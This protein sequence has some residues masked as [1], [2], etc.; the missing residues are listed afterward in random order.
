MKPIIENIIF[1]LLCITDE[2]EELW[3]SDPV[4]YIRVKFD[5]FEDYISPKVAAQTLLHTVCKKRK[6]MLPNSMSFAFGILQNASSTPR[7]IDG[8][9]HLIGAV[10]DLL[11]KKDEYKS[12]I[13]NMLVAYIFPHFLSAQGYLRARACWVLHYFA[14]TRF[15]NENHLNQA[16]EHVLR[17]LLKDQELP[18][19]VEAALCL[20]V[21]ITEQERCQ[22]LMEQHCRDVTIEILK[23][24]R[25]TENEDLTNVMQKLVYVYSEQLMPI[26]VEITQHLADTFNHVANIDNEADEEN[27]DRGLAAMGIL[28]TLDSVL[29]MMEDNKEIMA[30]L[31]PIV[32]HLV[33]N[34]LNRDMLELY[35]EAMT[36]LTTLSLNVVSE[37]MWKMLPLLYNIFKKEGVDYFTDMMPILHNYATVDPNGLIS[38]ADRFAAIFEMCHGILTNDEAGEDA[39]AHA[40]KLLE[41][42]ILQF[43]GQDGFLQQAI[44]RFVEL[45]M[46]RM[47][48][49]V[50][51]DDLK[52][53]CMIVMIAA[54]YSSPEIFFETLNKLQPPNAPRSLIDTFV[55][56]WIDDTDMFL[57]LHDRKINVLGLTTLMKLPPQSRPPILNEMANQ[58]VPSCLL[59]FEKLK[60]A[61][62]AKAAADNES[63]DDDDEDGEY[64]SDDEIDQASDDD[65]HIGGKRWSDFTPIQMEGNDKESMQS[66]SSIGKFF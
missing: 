66:T 22:K 10:A 61:Y 14:D 8:A 52:T 40:A 19:K 30:Q 2:D 56:Q 23:I 64:D 54:F 47:T 27:E 41:V 63:D 29:T 51:T 13:E 18:V 1:P 31:E 6:G 17:C 37:N 20:Q 15:Q 26:A 5:V 45:V 28:N 32:L 33:V 60:L 42:M 44:P 12:Q 62:Q 21:L 11:Q 50:K 46:S 43:K 57:G 16:F 9:L 65:E 39:Q 35:E 59:L 49:E 48:R 38:D 53:Q 34:I 24:I 58:I 25:E 3:T 36:L 7:H 55:K 4:E